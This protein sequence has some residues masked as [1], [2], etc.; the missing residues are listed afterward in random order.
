MEV[1]ESEAMVGLVSDH[2]NMML[3]FLGKV[4]FENEQ[5]LETHISQEDRDE[6]VV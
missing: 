4:F 1:R 6:L 5:S 2:R 3:S